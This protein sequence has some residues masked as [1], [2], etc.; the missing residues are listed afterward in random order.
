MN[1]AIKTIVKVAVAAVILLTL[2]VGG[3]IFYIWYSGQNESDKVVIKDVKPD[4]SKKT[5]IAPVKQAENARVGVV[6]Q[7]VTSPVMPGD[8]TSITMKTNVGAKCTVAVVY[9]KI[10]STDSGLTPKVADEYGLV[11]WTWTVD[12]NAA[13]GKWPVKVTCVKGDKSGVA[14]GQLEIVKTIEN[15]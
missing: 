4:T 12:K 8:N 9:D 2:I 15:K 7:T 5:S 11:S 13:L 6:L 14:S 1:K 3:G 10:P